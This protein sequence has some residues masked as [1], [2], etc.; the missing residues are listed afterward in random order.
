LHP[1]ADPSSCI[2]SV[3]IPAWMLRWLYIAFS[4]PPVA[5]FDEITTCCATHPLQEVLD[6]T[7]IHT[8]KTLRY[9]YIY[10]IRDQPN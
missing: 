6:R 2:I 9:I 8:F 4:L 5:M 7:K 3:N 10:V 1:S